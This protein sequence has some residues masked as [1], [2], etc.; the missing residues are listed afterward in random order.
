MDPDDEETSQDQHKPHDFR[1]EFAGNIDDCFRMGIK[2]S[3]KHMK[4]FS[5]FYS[6]DIIVASPLGLRMVVGD[7][8]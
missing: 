8:G 5:D 6:S 4:L 3:R 2:F 7:D 1:Q